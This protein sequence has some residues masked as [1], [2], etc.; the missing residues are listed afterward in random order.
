MPVCCSECAATVP[1][2]TQ[3][4]PECGASVI[5]AARAR[6]NVGG[7]PVRLAGVLGYFFVPSVIFLLLEPYKSH[8]FV[9]FH[10][11]QSI[12]FF[13]AGIVIGAVLSVAGMFFG[14]IPALPLLFLSMLFGLAFV[15]VW[16]VLVV[17]ALQG[18]MMKLPWLGDFAE[19]QTADGLSA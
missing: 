11:L 5:A 17:K 2:G 6:G 7:I 4:C 19:A 12:G 10:A 18:E 9:R 16:M 15:V 14:L 1:T 8:R 13:L 3:L